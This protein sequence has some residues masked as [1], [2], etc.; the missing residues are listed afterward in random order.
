M[1]I[2]INTRGAYVHVKDEMFEVRVKDPKTKEVSKTPI[3]AHKI[4]SIIFTV[5]SALSTDAVQLALKHNIDILFMDHY[6]KPMGRVWHSKLGSTTLIR[7]EQLKASIGS[8]AIVWIKKWLGKKIGNQLAFI[9]DLKKHRSEKFG[10]YLNDKILRISKIA[11]SVA[12]LEGSTIK[13]MA[14]TVRGLEGTA[15]RL[16]FEV[17]SKLLVKTYPFSG[18]SAR[19]AKDPFNAFLNYGFG[20]LYGKTEKVLIIA[21]ID[22]FVGFLHR[23]DYNHKSMVYDFI[24]P[25][26]IYVERVVFGLFSA[27]KV[28][29]AHT[30]IITNGF[31]LNKEGKELLIGAFNK[32]FEEDK[33]KY[34]NRL[35][36]RYYAMQL[37]AHQFANKLIEKSKTKDN[38]FV[39]VV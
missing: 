3:A 21:G 29:K 27:K 7:K 4:R 17:L 26:R 35:L 33:I 9:K 25:Y 23:D 1:E 28:N 18:R 13:D 24:E 34:N 16:Y 38:D 6:G 31:S 8:E 11:D 36:T 5:S 32:Y 39:G 2:Y 15:G 19:P 14:E 12:L 22:P 10:D 20:I 37:D 30:D